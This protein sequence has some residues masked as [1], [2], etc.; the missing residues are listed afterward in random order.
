MRTGVPFVE[1]GLGAGPQ[2]VGLRSAGL[3]H[4]LPALSPPPFDPAP[5]TPVALQ[6]GLGLGLWC[7]V[8]G[9]LCSASGFCSAES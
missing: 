7:C 9:G 2:C 3:G 1:R 5:G 6:S 8:P 4:Q